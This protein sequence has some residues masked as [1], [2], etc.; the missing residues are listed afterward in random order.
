MAAVAF[1]PS[2]YSIKLD[3]DGVVYNSEDVAGAGFEI[4]PKS[5]EEESDHSRNILSG[6]ET[7][8]K[9]EKK[10]VTW[11]A[12]IARDRLAALPT[13]WEKDKQHKRIIIKE[14]SMRQIVVKAKMLSE[15]GSYGD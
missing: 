15:T 4:V 7:V 10:D 11:L 6:G 14:Q 1:C 13:K 2:L 8:I 12:A 5:S 9:T 3:R